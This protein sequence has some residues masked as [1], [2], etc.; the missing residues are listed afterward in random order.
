MSNINWDATDR[1]QNR[2]KD[3]VMIV[4]LVDDVSNRARASELQDDG[5]N[6]CDVVRQ[7]QEPACGYVFQAQRGDPIK[8]THQQPAEKIEH[9]FSGGHGRHRLSFTIGVR[10]TAI[11][12]Y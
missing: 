2:V 5:I 7:K 6:P 11:G 3:R 1:A 12:K 10:Q 9:T 8:A 4:L